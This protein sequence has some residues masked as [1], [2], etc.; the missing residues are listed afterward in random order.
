MDSI[1]K[2]Q[3]SKQDAFTRVLVFGSESLPHGVRSTVLKY[4]D[5]FISHHG[6]RQP[7]L[8]VGDGEGAEAFAI[9]FAIQR[10]L[11][12][13]VLRVPRKG[14]REARD[15]IAVQAC[16]TAIG[17]S[18]NE[19]ADDLPIVQLLKVANKPTEFYGLGERGFEIRPWFKRSKP[20]HRESTT[21]P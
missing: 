8:L 13:V 17:F 9:D 7:I 20:S 6:I 1:F 15:W 16:D 4:I 12:R 5:G 21:T 19:V 10:G 3:Q 2:A 14:G 11:P 18:E